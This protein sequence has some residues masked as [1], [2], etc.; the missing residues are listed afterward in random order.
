MIKAL[1]TIACV[2]F[3]KFTFGQTYAII[4]DKMIDTKNGKVLQN[5]TVIVYKNH[6]TGINFNNQ[7]PDSAITIN[8][9]GYTLLPGLM[10]MHTHILADG[11]DYDKDLYSHSPAYRSLR[12]VKYLAALLD[13]GVTTI[14]DVCTEGAGFSDYDISRAVDSGFIAGPW[15]IPSGKGIAAT[16]RYLPSGTDQN[17]ELPLPSGTQ[18]ATGHDECV[19]AVREQISHGEKWI[20]LYADWGTPTFDYEE[21]KAIVSEARKYGVNVAAHATSKQGIKM[22]IDAGVR[23]IEHGDAFNDSLIN[24]ALAHHVFWCPTITVYEY[25]HEP[26]DTVYKYLNR[27]YKLNL[28]IVMGTDIGSFPWMVNDVKELEYYVKRA[29]FSPMDAIKTATVNSAELLN[30]SDKLGQIS[31]SFIADIIAVK[32]NPADDITLLQNVGFVMKSGKIIKSPVTK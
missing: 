17:W 30:K 20:K 3:V 10:D 31:V 26:M 14:R 25:Y 22:A 15:V 1:L 8:L 27:A 32:G 24:L 6:I 23:S 9:K 2:F 29:G 18:F 4:A 12:A 13:R 21:I 16:G 7:I 5:P 19:K 28:K 11:G